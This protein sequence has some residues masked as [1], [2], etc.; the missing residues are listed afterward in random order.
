MKPDSQT[1]L[2]DCQQDSFCWTID[3]HLQAFGTQVTL[4]YDA[5]RGRFG[6]MKGEGSDLT[7]AIWDAVNKIKE[8]LND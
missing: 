1:T 4:S 3:E 5:S 6:T 7:E 8:K 2:P